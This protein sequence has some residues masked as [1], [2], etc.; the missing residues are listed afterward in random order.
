MSFSHNRFL[1]VHRA[2]ARRSLAITTS[3]L[4][5]VVA[6]GTSGFMIVEGWGPAQALYFT[7][8]TLTTIG[9]GDYGLS[10]A[11]RVFTLL[12]V[13]GGLGAVTYW[14]GQALPLLF[15]H[16]LIW[17]RKMKDRIHKLEDHFI[18]C[19]LGRI[20]RAVCQYLAREGVDFIAIDQNA[21]E[22]AQVLEAGQLA[23]VGDAT[24]D[25]V[26]E[27]A[28]IRQARAIA[29]VAGSDTQNIVIT[30]TAR[31]R[32]PNLVIVSRAEHEDAIRKIERAGATRVI[33]P[34]RSGGFSIVNAILRPN[35]A[36]FLDRTHDR[37]QDFELA[38]ISIE[39]GSAL[40]GSTVRDKSSM[41]E[42]VAL[43]ALKRPDTSTRLRP[44]AD[45]TLHGGDVLIVAG[46]ALTIEALQRD[47]AGRRAA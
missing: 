34:V 35:L 1:P 23:L 37:A 21:E 36:D 20:G 5:G 42:H 45:E 25:H 19:G 12:L 44:A 9:Y 40:D 4:L 11:G 18:V 46:E 22:V 24:D 26:L 29:C 6:L 27:E 3:V 43:I 7:I 17:E 28:G 10:E 32:N 16:Q 15:N 14:A 30:L 38:E 31:E 47:A 41:H 13:V 33:S 39:P 8:I 2:T